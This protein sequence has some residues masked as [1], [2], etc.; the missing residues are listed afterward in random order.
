MK[1]ILLW[2]WR[3]ATRQAVKRPT[4]VGLLD[5]GELILVDDAGSAQVLSAGTTTV[6]RNVLQ[7]RQGG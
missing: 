7:Q 3:Y 2:L 6:I 1:R 4:R 5:T